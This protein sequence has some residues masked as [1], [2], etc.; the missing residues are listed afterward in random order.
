MEATRRRARALSDLGMVRWV[1]AWDKT[2]KWMIA[3][4]RRYLSLRPLSLSQKKFA[5]LVNL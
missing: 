5:F 2:C 3:I 1:L 4:M